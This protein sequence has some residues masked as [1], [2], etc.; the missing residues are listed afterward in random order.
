MYV[1]DIEAAKNF[2]GAPRRR[3]TVGGLWDRHHEFGKHDEVIAVESVNPV[4]P[5]GLHGGDDL[6]IEYVC[7]GDG[8]ALQQS[9]PSR[10]S[11]G[12]GW[13]HL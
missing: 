11:A 10:N 6:Q 4:D 5:V 7:A 3:E 13:Q 2:D 1:H 12:R 8:V 9:H